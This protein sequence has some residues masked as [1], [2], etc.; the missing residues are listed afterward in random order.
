MRAELNLEPG[1]KMRLKLLAGF[2]DN[3]TFSLYWCDRLCSGSVWSAVPSTQKER[4]SD[5]RRDEELQGYEN[6]IKS[7]GILITGAWY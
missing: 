5:D 6:V 2:L 4:E 1:L 3:L 7:K